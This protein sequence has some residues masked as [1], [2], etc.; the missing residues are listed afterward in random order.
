MPHPSVENASTADRE[1]PIVKGKTAFLSVDMQYTEWTPEA[2]EAAKRGDGD[3]KKRDYH[4]RLSDIVIPNQ[5]RLQT[6]ARAAGVEVMFT[7]IEALTQD[8]RDISLDHKIS[9]IFVPK[10]SRD[11]QVIDAVAP[12][13]DEIVIPKTASGI[14]NSTNVEYVLRNLGV[15]CLVV[16]GICTDQCVETSVR[17]ACDRGF[18]VTLVEDCCATTDHERHKRSIEAVG[19][20]YAR[21]RSTDEMIAELGALQQAA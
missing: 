12:V 17:D 6:A 3:P 21:V 2:A 5:K 9:G 7:V 10:G 4:N 1:R 14:F 15:E 20:H 11:A 16:Y 13:G 19:G 8:G 18:L